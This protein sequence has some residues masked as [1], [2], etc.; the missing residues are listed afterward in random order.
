[1][2]L[3]HP[4]LTASPEGSYVEGISLL[5]YAFVTSF[6]WIV[7]ALPFRPKPNGKVYLNSWCSGGN[8]SLN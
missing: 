6:N 3:Y 5:I 2:Q 7:I 8:H 4:R 1:M